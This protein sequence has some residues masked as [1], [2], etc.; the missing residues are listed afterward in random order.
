MNAFGTHSAGKTFEPLH[1]RIML[2][3]GGFVLGSV[4]ASAA[5]R[6]KER[7]KYAGNLG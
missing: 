3:K 5:A 6:V 2:K 1:L 7:E 4:D